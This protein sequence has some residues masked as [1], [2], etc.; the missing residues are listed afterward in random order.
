ME[1]NNR[2]LRKSVPVK[3]SY[4]VIRRN[5][6][7]KVLTSFYNV[8][9]EI[10][11]SF[12]NPTYD[13]CTRKLSDWICDLITQGAVGRLRDLLDASRHFSE[14]VRR[15]RQIKAFF[16][17]Q[18]FSPKANDAQLCETISLLF[19]RFER[20]AKVLIL[21]AIR[22]VNVGRVWT[23]ERLKCCRVSGAV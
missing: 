18:M 17:L 2:T 19:F 5:F 9:G 16:K 13:I 23:A 7:I 22:S 12:R 3:K 6:L 14:W 21:W 10:N 15:H 8:W 20:I 11:R 4:Y 1:W